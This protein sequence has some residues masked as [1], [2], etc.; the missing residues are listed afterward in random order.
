MNI[1]EFGD[2]DESTTL[3]QITSVLATIPYVRHLGIRVVKVEGA[4]GVVLQLPFE[5]RLVGNVTLP[6]IHG[7][8]VATLA[9]DAHT[10]LWDLPV[11]I[12]R[13]NNRIIANHYNTSNLLRSFKGLKLR[14]IAYALWPVTRDTFCTIVYQAYDSET[15][16]ATSQMSALGYIFLQIL[17][18]RLQ[19][20]STTF[21]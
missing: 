12:P 9:W 3:E 13:C 19:F 11:Q 14:C 16:I 5:A 18:T 4:R 21:I 6:A 17:F 1:K 10:C 2:C 7:G 20:L 15:C 8:V